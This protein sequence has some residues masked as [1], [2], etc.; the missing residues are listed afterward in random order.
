MSF[1]SRMRVY[2]LWFR[3]IGCE[4]GP[5]RS[6]PFRELVDPP[7]FTVYTLPIAPLPSSRPSDLTPE[8]V[9]CFKVSL[10]SLTSFGALAIL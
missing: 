2:Y 8:R 4:F 7:Y 3:K 9:S 10:I 1:Q 6:G 5:V